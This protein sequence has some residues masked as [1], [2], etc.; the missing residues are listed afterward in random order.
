[1]NEFYMQQWTLLD[2]PKSHKIF[3]LNC[4]YLSETC[5]SYA[6]GILYF[7]TEMF[8]I[9]GKLQQMSCA[10]DSLLSKLQP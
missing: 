9:Y 8:F 10:S 4:K 2:F 3:I 5:V 7:I 6:L 1:M